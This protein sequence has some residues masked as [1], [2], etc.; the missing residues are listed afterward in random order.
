LERSYP[1]GKYNKKLVN[2]RWEIEFKRKFK[3]TLAA[4]QL[5]AEDTEQVQG[6]AQGLRQEF[7]RAHIEC[8]VIYCI[9]NQSFRV[10][11]VL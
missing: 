8:Y 7:S 9:G 6:Y 4:F 5:K 3:T 2:L 11:R 10:F 1:K